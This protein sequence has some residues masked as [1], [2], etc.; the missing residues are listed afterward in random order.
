MLKRALATALSG[1]N[2]GSITIGARKR[3]GYGQVNVTEWRC[4]EYTL[5]NP[6]ELLDWIAHGAD[7]LEWNCQS[8]HYA[9]S[10]R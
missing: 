5:I 1:F 8:E 9:S 10:R 7:D 2:D 4:K 3:R 6:T